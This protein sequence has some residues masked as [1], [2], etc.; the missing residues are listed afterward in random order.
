M[1]KVNFRRATILLLLLSSYRFLSPP[2]GFCGLRLRASRILNRGAPRRSHCW[3]AL[4]RAN[5]KCEVRKSY[6][7]AMPESVAL[8]KDLHAQGISY[9]KTVARLSSV[10]LK[11]ARAPLEASRVPGLSQLGVHHR[12]CVDPASSAEETTTA[13]R[14]L[15]AARMRRMGRERA[16]ELLS[17]V[18]I[19]AC[20]SMEIR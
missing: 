18:S 3:G 17:W 8:A 1:A 9:R 11:A 13:V 20:F 12:C 5:G 19:Q 6:A 15:A 14:C 10:E 2:P 7:E 4:P 16:G